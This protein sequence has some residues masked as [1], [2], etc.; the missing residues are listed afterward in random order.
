MTQI[1][2]L[3]PLLPPWALAALGV[4]ALVVLGFAL[5]R[6]LKGWPWRAVA[7]GLVLMALANPAL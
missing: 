3:Q 4:A 6:G 5:W 2:A 7:L 1:V